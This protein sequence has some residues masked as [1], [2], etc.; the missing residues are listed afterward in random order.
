MVLKAIVAYADNKAIGK[1]NDLIWHLPDDLKHFKDHTRGRSIIMG[2]KTWDSLGGRPLP[3]RRHI[4]I[5]R[6][7]GWQEQGCEVVPNLEAALELVKNE[8]EAFIVGGAQIYEL[9]MPYV[10]ILEITEVHHEFDAHAYFPD[11]DQSPFE[12]IA[13]TFHPAD[14]NHEY[15]FTFKTWKRR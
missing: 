4:V 1:D 13:E 11:W 9:A 5:T 14:E 2:R 6:Q 12:L 15:S 3:K 7:E 10:D 8:E